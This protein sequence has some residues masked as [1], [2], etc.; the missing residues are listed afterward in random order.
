MVMWSLTSTLSLDGEIVAV[1]GNG[2][3]RFKLFQ[4]FQ[5]QSTAP[6]LYYFFN[7]LWTDGKNITEKTVIEGKA[8]L[9]RIIKPAPG[10]RAIIFA[11]RAI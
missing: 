3:P 1:D 10:I 4:R 6:T 7:A 9:E 8:V 5:K 11:N 2:I